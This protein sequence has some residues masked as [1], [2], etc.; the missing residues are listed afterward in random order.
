M[1]E[2]DLCAG[3]GFSRTGQRETCSFE[4]L[5]HHRSGAFGF[6]VL[7]RI[8]DRTVLRVVFSDDLFFQRQLP[9]PGPFVE[10]ADGVDLVDQPGKKCVSRGFGEGSMEGCVGLGESEWITDRGFHAGAESVEKFKVFAACVEDAEAAN[11][12]F[13]REASVDEFERRGFLDCSGRAFVSGG[14]D[15]GAA[16]GSGFEKALFFELVKRVA[17][18]IA[19]DAK[20]FGHLARRRQSVESFVGAIFDGAAHLG[21]DV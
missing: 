5:F 8:Q 2:A 4:V 20:A 16:A 10:R 15:I 18:R 6:A 7:D 12:R 14:G 3:L 1:Y 11:V 9:H 17:E 19:C 21:R 13:Q